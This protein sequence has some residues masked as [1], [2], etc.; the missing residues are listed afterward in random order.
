MKVTPEAPLRF[1]DQAD[2]FG[3]GQIAL[4]VIGWGTGF[5]DYDNDGWLDLYAVNGS[6]FQEES[7]PTRLVPMR[8]FLFWNAGE[9]RLLRGGPA[10]RASRSPRPRV[11][12]GASFADYD[13]DGDLDIADRGPRRRAAPGAQRG[14]QPAR[15]GSGSSCAPRRGRHTADGACGA[16]RPLRPGRACA[17]RPRAGRSCAQVGGQSSYLSQEPP[18]EVFFGTGDAARDRRARG[19]LAERPGAVLR[20]PAGAGHDPDPRGRRAA[21]GG[22]RGD[23]PSRAARRSWRLRARRPRVR[24]CRAPA[25]NEAASARDPQRQR[26]LDFWER[27]NAATEARSRRDLRRGRAP[28]RGGPRARPPARGRALLPRPVPPRAGPAERGARRLRAA[29]RGQPRER[30]RAPRARRAARLARPARADGPRAGRA[31]PAARPRD[32]RR[33][34]GARGAPGRGRCS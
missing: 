32:Q 9:Q 2:L 20:G 14:R 21:A 31:A 30:A 28:L 33:G 4:D 23:E 10:G 1:V 5:L 18:G 34:D 25:G 24:G 26:V 6:T 8:S 27:L 11:G 19:A 3:L 29:G 15:L 16:R 12:R 13:G 7:D 22:R 17:S